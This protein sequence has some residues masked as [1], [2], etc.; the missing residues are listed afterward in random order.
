MN[1]NPMKTSQ[2]QGD[3]SLKTNLQFHKS[4]PKTNIYMNVKMVVVNKLADEK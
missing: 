4:I 3:C 1:P 2:N